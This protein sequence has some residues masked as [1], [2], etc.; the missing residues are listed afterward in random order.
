MYYTKCFVK[1]NVRDSDEIVKI[2]N[3]CHYGIVDVVMDNVDKDLI[4]H[5]GRYI[6]IKRYVDDKYRSC[7]M[8]DMMCICKCIV[9]IDE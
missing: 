2:C 7:R 4:Q 5:N 6:K 9:D 3:K 8:K 1:F